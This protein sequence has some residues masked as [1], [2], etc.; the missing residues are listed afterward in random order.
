MGHFDLLS[1]WVLPLSVC[2]FR[3]AL[4]DEDAGVGCGLAPALPP[5]AYYYVVYIGLL[6]LTYAVAWSQCVSFS[7]QGNVSR[8]PRRVGAA[9]PWWR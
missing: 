8:R 6:G 2:C 7:V 9:R 5:Q 1:A 3:R 4:R